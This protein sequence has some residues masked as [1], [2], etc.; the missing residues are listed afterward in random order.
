MSRNVF[1]ARAMGFFCAVVLFASGSLQAQQSGATSRPPTPAPQQGVYLVFPFENA[2]ASP[3]LD[4]LGEGL[5]E[6]T[7]QYLSDSGVQVYSTRAAPVN[8]NATVFRPLRNSVAPLCCV[9]PR[10][11]TLTTSSSAPSPPMAPRSP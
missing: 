9:S 4:W 5:E 6:L 11:S 10:I 3:R 2:G 7:I 1:T 8:S